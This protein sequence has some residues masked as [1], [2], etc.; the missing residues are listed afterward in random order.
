LTNPDYRLHAD[1]EDYLFRVVSP[2]F[3]AQGWLGAFDVMTIARWKAARARDHFA[4]RLLSKGATSLENGA[5]SLTRTLA[6]AHSDEARFH[7]VCVEW[8]FPLATGSAFLTVC[9]PRS[10][11]VYDVRVCDQLQD[12][13]YLASRT[14]PA[15]LWGGYCAFV[16]A[17]RRAAP[18]G[19]SLRD[20]DRWHWGRSRFDDLTEYLRTPLAAR[21]ARRK[22]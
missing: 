21:A 2:R 19:L 4:R 5:K 6:S 16:A 14:K 3:A 12:F 7:T 1:D 20:C 11:T 17:V 22:G 18:A 13:K 15:S 10:F 9:F 8:G